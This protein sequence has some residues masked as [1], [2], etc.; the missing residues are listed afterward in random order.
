MYKEAIDNMEKAI[1]L[2]PLEKYFHESMGYIHLDTKEFNHALLCF[3]KVEVLDKKYMGVHFYK[4]QAYKGI[5]EY[6]KALKSVKKF[7]SAREWKDY[8]P[9]KQLRNKCLKLQKEQNK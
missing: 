2:D 7:L 4:A 8:E 5:G 6:D 3:R 1:S 9:A